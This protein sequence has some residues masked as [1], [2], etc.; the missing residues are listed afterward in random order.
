M[1]REPFIPLVTE[2][3]ASLL[4]ISRVV[5]YLVSEKILIFPERKD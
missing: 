3:I 1:R 5:T 2:H 4:I